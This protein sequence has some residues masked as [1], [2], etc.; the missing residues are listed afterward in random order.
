MDHPVIG[1]FNLQ[2]GRKGRWHLLNRPDHVADPRDSKVGDIGC[3][4]GCILVQNGPCIRKSIV[5]GDAEHEQERKDEKAR[6]P[7]REASFREERLAGFVYGFII[8]FK[9]HRKR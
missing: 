8:F 1:F 9:F 5:K 3:P 2:S 6:I 4:L 7:D